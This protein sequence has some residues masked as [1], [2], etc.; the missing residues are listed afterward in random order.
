MT[1]LGLGLDLSV[2][3]THAQAG[4]FRSDAPRGAVVEADCAD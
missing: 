2:N 4:I 3:E 1:Q